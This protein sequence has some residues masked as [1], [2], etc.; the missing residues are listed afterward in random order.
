MILNYIFNRKSII[1]VFICVSVFHVI[2]LHVL[3]F[4]KKQN[5]NR[6]V[7]LHRERRYKTKLKFKTHEIH[8]HWLPHINHITKKASLCDWVIGVRLINSNESE[9][10]AKKKFNKENGSRCG[11]VKRNCVLKRKKKIRC[12]AFGIHR[13]SSRVFEVFFFYFIE[14]WKL[15]VCSHIISIKET[16]NHTIYSN[17]MVRMGNQFHVK[18]NY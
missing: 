13:C 8:T 12:L 15:V 7:R 17:E 14:K 3:P 18:F 2:W 5:Y 6:P 4:R 16:H 9:M 11:R 1:I 10:D